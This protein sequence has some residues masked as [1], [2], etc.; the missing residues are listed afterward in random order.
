MNL[1]KSLRNIFG[2]K[3][4]GTRGYAEA[5]GVGGINSDWPLNFQT[6]DA[7]LWQNA[8]ALTSRV[9]DLFKTNP[10]YVA[11]RDSLWAQVF[12]AE[13]I[14]LRMRVK[15][16]EDRVVHS[17]DEKSAIE[18]HERRFNRVMEWKA[19]KHGREFTHRA[20]LHVTG[21]NG[22]TRATVKIGD[23]DIFANLIV[24][25]RWKEWQ[26]AE[27][28]DVRGT[29][30][31]HTLRQ[32][33]L[34]GAVRDGDIF[35]RMIKT[36]NVNKFGFTLRMINAEWCDRFYN[37]TLE[38]GNVI[39]MGIE[40]EFTPWGIG[41]VVAFHF[42]K[43]QPRDWQYNSYGLL[44][45]S[46]R[47]VST[48]HDRVPAEEI[49]HYARATDPEATRPAPWVA[50]TI[51]PSRQLDQAMIAE[52]VAWRE[53]A[54]KT[55]TYWSDVVPE[56]GVPDGIDPRAKLRESR[57]GPGD[58]EAL[59]YGVK[60]QQNDPTHPNASV[61]EFVKAA[62]QHITSGMPAANY[63]TLANDYG[64][65]NFSAG[66]LQRLDTNEINMQLQRFDID[67]AENKIFE[68]WLEMSLLTGVVPLPN[69]KFE[70]YNNKEFQGRRWQGVDPMKDANAS[71][72]DVAN[73]FSSRT[74]ECSFRG[75]DFEAI[76]FECAEE[77]MLL[78][79]LGLKTEM[80]VETPAV[81]VAAVDEPTDPPAGDTP[82]AVKPKPKKSRSKSRV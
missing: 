18:Q 73:H 26:R 31:Y 24:E 51:T 52:V 76:A 1:L 61:E 36:P 38:N 32:L 48:M 17:P 6:E 50:S 75:V 25:R 29:R 64:A 56:G 28:C 53:A 13:G 58:R 22:S 12:G 2:G 54:C 35:I 8:Y 33:R 9:R 68:N 72:T 19:S 3:K 41:K 15:E 62:K 65:I 46:N 5:A 60:Y 71:A 59:P 11:Y 23:P 7:D 27:F 69:S 57:M 4:A 14:M 81:Q 55:G 66:R 10:L 82:T 20:F 80:T 49:I 78:E 21:Q 42:I 39:R 79:M 43:R 37:V 30:N 74:R 77:E 44:G 47:G 16:N 70:K 67:Y 34:I 40:Y 45:F 63:S